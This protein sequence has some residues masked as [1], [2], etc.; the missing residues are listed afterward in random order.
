MNPVD[1]KPCIIED[2]D[3]WKTL[4]TERRFT[5]DYVQIDEVLVRTPSQP[6]RDLSWTVVKRKSA[7]AVAPMTEDGRFVMVQQ[8][9]VAPR[10]AFLEFP[11]GQID[12]VANRLE[13]EVILATVE[14]ELREEV[15]YRLAPGAKVTPMGYYFTSQGYSDE[16]IYLFAVSPVV[17]EE[18]GNDPD[19]SES[20]LGA[21]LV[22][23]SEL[24]AMI[25][26]G[27]ACD[28]LTLALFARLT[29]LGI[30]G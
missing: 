4:S 8:E 17:P 14:S 13:P 24:K 21:R 3:G 2:A 20:I 15:G 30:L 10:R 19:A 26:S 6:D 5:S 1:L 27:D 16:H 12:D 22:E 9:R 11:A 29:A 23:P 25:A 7:V 18:R 28:S